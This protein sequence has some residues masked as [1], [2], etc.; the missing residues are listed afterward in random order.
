MQRQNGLQPM[1]SAI[2]D[3]T[4]IQLDMNT[5][6]EQNATPDAIEEAIR[7][8]I[9]IAQLQANLKR[10]P[11]ERMARHDIA[12]KTANMLREGKRK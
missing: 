12:L 8:G 1:L 9:D 2:D 10:T 6:P 3:C 11:L 5:K 7:Y 4:N